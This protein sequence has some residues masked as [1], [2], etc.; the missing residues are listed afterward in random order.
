MM[1]LVIY[2]CTYYSDNGCRPPVYAL[3][4]FK[5]S[6]S[7]SESCRTNLERFRESKRRLVLSY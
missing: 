5:K 7:L 1:L 3:P 4:M 6:L 2:E